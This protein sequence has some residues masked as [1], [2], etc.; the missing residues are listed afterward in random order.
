MKYLQLFHSITHHSIKMLWS[1]LFIYF[2]FIPL[3]TLSTSAQTPG[4]WQ[5]YPAYTFCTRNIP[6]GNKI[7]GLMESKL[8]VYDT[9]DESITTFDWQRQ[10]NDIYISFID[11]SEEAKRIII[12]YD[13]GNIDL[14][15]TE[16]DNEV[17]NLAQLKESTLKNRQVR[18]V[19]VSGKMAYI[20]TGFGVMC[21]DM[22]E[23]NITNT[24]NLELAVNSCAITDDAIY[25]G[26]TN[27]I[28]KGEFE[29]N[30]L[31]KKNW[32]NI[33][34]IKPTWMD[35]FN[36]RICA[37]VNG[38][39]YI[40]NAALTNFSR[41]LVLD[42]ISYINV[43]DDELILGNDSLLYIYK[44]I[45]ENKLYTST[46]FT[47]KDIKKQGNLY[48]ASDGVD[49]LQSY[50]LNEEDNT[51]Q[52]K[53][54]QIYSNSPLHDFSYHLRF[55][56]GLLLVA[57]GNQNYAYSN[58]DGAAMILNKDGTWTNFDTKSISER[59]PDERFWDV[60]DISQDPKD[61]THYYVGTARSGIFEFKDNICIGHIGYDNSPLQTILPNDKNPQYFVVGNGIQYDDEGNLWVLNSRVDTIIHILKPNGTWK[62]LYYD[63]IAGISAID[64]YLFASNGY[65]WMNSRRVTNRGII[66]LDY[67]GTI[68][69]QT[70][71]K[72]VLHTTVINQDG[73]IYDPDGFYCVTEDTQ[74][75]IWIGTNLGPFVINN[76]DDFFKND[77]IYEQIKVS[78][79]DGSGFADYLL[80]GVPIL[81]I[82]L[83]GGGRIWFGSQGNGVYLMS[84]DC[85]EEIHHF[86]SDN[87][88]LI[89]DV[90]YDIVIDEE[91]GRVFFATDK[92]LCS[93]MSDATKSFEELD[94]NN[95]LAYPNPVTSDYNGPILVKGLV[96]DSEVKI[97]STSGHVIWSGKSNGGMFTWNG[98]NKQG[99]RVASG[100]YHVV[101]NTP[102]GESA[103]VTRIAFIR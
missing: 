23:A 53:T 48:W 72:I 46:H 44:N 37:Q 36:G 74:G 89:S 73:T 35:I 7:Y 70:D 93:Y 85:Q 33:H 80:Y 94:E 78:R 52:L 19:R 95:I 27:G 30:L 103:V 45:E 82:T 8:M 34:Y 50:V 17:I 15:S 56:N 64:N 88:P 63:E 62:S 32:E 81:S 42:N 75:R 31:E 13:N 20:C 77:F 69:N 3:F 84:A 51:F 55:V 87:S 41:K 101:A 40:S 60:T 49:G 58:R 47:W 102:D 83:D 86:T 65:V 28:W 43:S 29:K 67:G 96:Q 98:R 90:V 91:T 12:I 66:L 16:D 99:K 79:N 4:S 25:L 61:E 2:L 97:L 21:I 71:D 18:N 76:P 1:T 100:I 6:V 92:G 9:E 14:L 68:D 38:S 5:I 10:L 11:Y 39:F 54:S 59:F 22:S 24:Y 26:T 57:G